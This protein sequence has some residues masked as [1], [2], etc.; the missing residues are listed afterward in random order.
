MTQAT[1]ALEDPS[2]S[3]Q[4]FLSC[5]WPPPKWADPDG[6]VIITSTRHDGPGNGEASDSNV[7]DDIS[8]PCRQFRLSYVFEAQGAQDAIPPF[9]AKAGLV[10]NVD[11]APKP[12]PGGVGALGFYPKLGDVVV[13]RNNNDG[14]IAAA[15]SS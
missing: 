4:R 3:N 1:V 13:L 15:C 9:T 6:F 2:E 8:G 14:L 10:T 12:W 5:S 11:Q 7:A